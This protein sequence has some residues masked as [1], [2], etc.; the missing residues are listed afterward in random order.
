[1]PPPPPIKRLYYSLNWNCVFQ[2][3]AVRIFVKVS[4]ASHQTH[5]SAFCSLRLFC[6]ET[7]SNCSRTA[8]SI[9]IRWGSNNRV[10]RISLVGNNT[11]I[12]Q[13]IHQKRHRTDFD[14]DLWLET[15]NFFIIMYQKHGF[16]KLCP[17]LWTL[18]TKITTHC[19]ENLV[20]YYWKVKIQ[21]GQVRKFE[22]DQCVCGCG[23][24]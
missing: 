17:K 3:F 23:Y 24:V 19:I 22:R 14:A 12:S 4:G 2:C 7:M 6:Y 9:V 5:A 16:W 13:K 21:F 11:K 20:I 8:E 15:W 1:M 18:L 10:S